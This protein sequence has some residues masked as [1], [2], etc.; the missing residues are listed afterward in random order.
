MT[1]EIALGELRHAMEIALTIAGPLLLVVLVTGVVVG[2]L[3]AATQINEPTVAFVAKA[4][5][6]VVSIAVGGGWL[7]EQL[8]GFTTA[9][10][11]RIPAL[12]G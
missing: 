4:I 1:P 12:I 6:L 11:Q 2:V 5:V 8:V 7:L 10:F 3:Q 9:L